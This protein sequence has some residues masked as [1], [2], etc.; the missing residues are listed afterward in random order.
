MAFYRCYAPDAVPLRELVRV[1]GRRWTIEECFQAGNGLAGLDKHR[2]RPLDLLA[3]LDAAGDDRT[4]AA[5]STRRQRAR[6]QVN[7]AHAR[8]RGP[9][10]RANAQLKSW[11]ILRKIR[12]CPRPGDRSGQGGDGADPNRLRSSWKELTGLVAMAPTPSISGPPQPLPAT[13]GHAV[14][15]ITT[16]GW[17]T[18]EV[19]P[20]FPLVLFATAADGAAQSAASGENSATSGIC[21]LG[22][23]MSAATRDWV[24]FARHATCCNGSAALSEDT[25]GCPSQPRKLP[26]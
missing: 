18:Q 25:F 2:G 23:Q 19:G 10:E 12:S 3:T 17:R 24:D 9:G 5:C 6:K 14:L 16:Y 13:T 22:R 11:Q 15:S 8:Q 1:A 20:V 4:R 7:T 21:V 26:D